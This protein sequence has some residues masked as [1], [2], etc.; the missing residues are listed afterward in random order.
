MVGVLSE[1]TGGIR[2][3]ASIVGQKRIL[4]LRA[5][6]LTV[7]RFVRGKPRRLSR[8]SGLT[9]VLDVADD[10]VIDGG[11]LGIEATIVMPVHVTV[12]VE[13][14]AHNCAGNVWSAIDCEISGRGIKNRAETSI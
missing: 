14:L 12:G 4:T 9:D 5:A 13:I 7:N 2:L 8:Y 3:E 6:A 11:T 10:A 1:T